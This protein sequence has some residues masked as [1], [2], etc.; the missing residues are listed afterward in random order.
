MKYTILQAVYNANSKQSV[1][2]W[3]LANLWIEDTETQIQIPERIWEPKVIVENLDS[4]DSMCTDGHGT[5]YICDSRLKR[6]Y[7]WNEKSGKIELLLSTHY[8]PLSLA[9]DTMG[10]LLMVIE[11]RPVKYAKK[12][13]VLELDMEE[14][15]ERSRGDFGACFYP[16]FRKD[17]R[18]RVLS[19]DTKKGESSFCELEPKARLNTSLDRLYYPV[20]QWR[21]NGDMKSVIQIP[22]ETCYLAPDGITGITNNPALAR[23]TGLYA[24]QRNE[25]FYAVDE[26]NKYVIKLKVNQNLDLL[27]PT[28]VAYR[29]E[30]SAVASGNGELYIPDNLL[31]CYKS[32]QVRMITFAKR[33][34]CVI[35]GDKEEKYL[36]ISAR[37]NFYVMKVKE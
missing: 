19:I 12:E 2:D 3:Q 13:A 37:S 17:R 11:Y 8:R 33:P 30:Y 7:K 21:D 18:I 1:G 6:I 20:N 10:N 9:C 23:A 24:V 31:Y 32:G 16:F 34:A 25:V 26:Y 28:I 14:Y 36:Y 29:G 35:W 22:D 15:G 4:I 27:D 5:L